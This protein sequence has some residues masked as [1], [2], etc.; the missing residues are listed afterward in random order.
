MKRLLSLLF[1]I[2]M[3]FSF[4]TISRADNQFSIGV[5]GTGNGNTSPCS[6][7][8]CYSLGTGGVRIA[9]IDQN[10]NK[11][12]G[13]IDLWYYGTSVGMSTETN[14]MPTY[15]NIKSLRQ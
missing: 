6:S 3:F 15:F 2:V 1:M 4:I 9:L 13:P 5:S 12:S 11:V 8:N 7:G 10:G 14:G